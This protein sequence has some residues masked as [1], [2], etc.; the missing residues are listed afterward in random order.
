MK[1]YLLTAVLLTSALLLA[2]CAQDTDA[3][4]TIGVTASTNDGQYEDL[5]FQS[6]GKRLDATFYRAEGEGP[7]PN[8]ILLHGYPAN[9]KRS[10]LARLMQA[11]GFNVF[12][13][14]YR[15]AYGSE[16]TF[17]FTHALEDVAAATVFL[18]DNAG[19]F[20][21]DP[22]KI[23]L[24][25]HSMGGFA[26]LQNGARDR[27]IGC[28]AAL[29]PADLGAAAAAFKESPHLAAG[30]SAYSDTLHM[31][32]GWS[33]DAAVAEIIANQ[34]AFDLRPLAPKFA[35]RTVLIVGA[36]QDASVPAETVIKPLF[37]AFK[38]EPDVNATTVM[39]SGDHTFSWSRDALLKT[40]MDWSKNC[41]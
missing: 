12:M 7:H 22:E 20:H 29:A 33:G 40:V 4:D 8:F 10:D 31:L 9:E 17:S 25:G 18:R 27:R 38:S 23:N 24:L 32:N 11:V 37:A 1:R 36:D 19:K 2:A 21:A 39:L 34:E 5:S 3:S 41:R 30:F 28:V 13:F 14:H 6:A 16:G 35:G 26:A 15:G